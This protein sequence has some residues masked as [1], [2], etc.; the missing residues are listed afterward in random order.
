MA[1]SALDVQS[2]RFLDQD[3][4]TTRTMNFLPTFFSLPLKFLGLEFLAIAFDLEY[5][6]VVKNKLYVALLFLNL[7]FILTAT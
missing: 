4:P 1:S 3:V 6:C 2:G 7:I 5:L